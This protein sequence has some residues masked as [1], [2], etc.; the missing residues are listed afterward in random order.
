MGGL[1]LVVDGLLQVDESGW[2][3][4]VTAGACIVGVSIIAFVIVRLAL[5]VES[6][7]ARLH[8]VM[9]EFQ[10]SL[11]QFH[12]HLADISS[13]TALSDTAKSIAHRAKERE[14]LRAAIYDQIRREDFEAVFHLI[15]DLASHPGYKDEAEQLRQE[16][17][18]QCAEAF[19][20]K[21]KVAI[22]H[23]TKL[24]AGRHWQQATHEIERLEKLM[25]AEPRVKELWAMLE[26][27][28]DQ[29]KRALLADW[30]TAVANGNVEQGIDLLK[31]L[32]QY[33][34]SDEAKSMQ[35]TAREMFKERLLLLG[36]QFQFAVKEKRWRDALSAGLEIIEEFPN[37]RMADEIRERLA[38][39]RER[40]GIPTD[41]DVTARNPSPAELSDPTAG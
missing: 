37:S 25:P 1:A 3:W 5:K 27:E 38:A 39:L 11:N 16:T 23:V 34:T 26:H 41:V 17:R 33:V 19:R 2:I 28:R 15:G 10:N 40:A 29:R 36:V 30:K 35:A 21:L 20:I 32:D 13:N 22:E 12:R 18:E 7:S 6:N 14:S 4:L 24:L 8:D 31:E 9:L